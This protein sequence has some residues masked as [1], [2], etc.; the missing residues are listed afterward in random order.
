MY[1]RHMA[2]LYDRFGDPT[3]TMTG[4]RRVRCVSSPGKKTFLMYLKTSC[5]AATPLS[6]HPM[7]ITGGLAMRLTHLEP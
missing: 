7:A 5:A 2:I 6:Y 3:A 1:G 4:L